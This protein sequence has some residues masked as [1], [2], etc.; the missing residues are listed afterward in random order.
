MEVLKIFDKSENIN[1]NNLIINN[2]IK[3]LKWDDFSEIKDK[4][5]NFKFYN[6]KEKNSILDNQFYQSKQNHEY[7]VLSKIKF[8]KKIKS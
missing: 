8:Y 6:Q 7:I 1:Q 4:D 3:I 5:S 2:H